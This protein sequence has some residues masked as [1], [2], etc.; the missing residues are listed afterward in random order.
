M[1]IGSRYFKEM[2]ETDQLCCDFPP[3][4]IDTPTVIKTAVRNGWAY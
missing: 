3:S 1:S 2:F 4:V